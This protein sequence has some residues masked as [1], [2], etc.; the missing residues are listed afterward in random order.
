MIVNILRSSAENLIRHI[1]W[2]ISRLVDPA[3]VFLKL[4]QKGPGTES[5]RPP[6]NMIN[7]QIYHRDCNKICITDA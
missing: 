4:P 6:Q 7:S 1:I 2:I 3:E 5:F